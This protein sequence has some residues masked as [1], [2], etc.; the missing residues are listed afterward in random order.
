MRADNPVDE[1]TRYAKRW[2]MNVVKCVKSRRSD[3]TWEFVPDDE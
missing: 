1:H 2:A 3:I